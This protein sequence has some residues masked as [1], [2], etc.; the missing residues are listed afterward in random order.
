MTHSHSSRQSL[1]ARIQAQL[2]RKPMA[3]IPTKLRLPEEGQS[4]LCWTRTS[5]EQENGLRAQF[6]SMEGVFKDGFF[7]VDTD[8]YSIHE[9]EAWTGLPGIAKNHAR[10]PTRPRG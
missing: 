6:N 5:S 2:D 9:V 8:R 1:M 7:F 3:T 10:V 4:V